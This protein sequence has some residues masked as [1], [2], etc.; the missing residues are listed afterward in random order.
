MFGLSMLNSCR[1]LGVIGR[2]DF[3]MKR[4]VRQ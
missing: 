1:K 4:Q 3:E 2:V